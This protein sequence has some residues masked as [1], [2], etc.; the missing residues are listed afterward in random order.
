MS[1]I[2]F[3]IDI[4]ECLSSPCEHICSNTLGS[5]QCSCNSGY[6][7][8]FNGRSC[9]GR[10]LYGIHNMHTIYVCMHTMADTE[11]NIEHLYSIVIY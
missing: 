8:D 3:L 5:F 10:Q 6:Q 4:D 7:L 2:Y 9:S 1:T 11:Y